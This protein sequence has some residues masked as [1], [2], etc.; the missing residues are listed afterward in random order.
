MHDLYRGKACI[1][2]ICKSLKEGAMK[3]INFKTKKNEV[4]KKQ[5]QQ[6][7]EK[8]KMH[9]FCKKQFDNKYVKDKKYFKVRD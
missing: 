6:S 8:V 4:I 7:Y 3:I 2:K 5:Q 9:Y 1:K